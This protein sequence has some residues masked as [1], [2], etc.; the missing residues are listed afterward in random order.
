M[1][2]FQLVLD[3]AAAGEPDTETEGGLRRC[4]YLDPHFAQA[5]Y[6]LGMMLEQRGSKA[7]AGKCSETPKRAAAGI[8]CFPGQGQRPEQERCKADAAK[9]GGESGERSSLPAIGRLR[10]PVIMGIPSAIVSISGCGLVRGSF[11]RFRGFDQGNDGKVL[12]CE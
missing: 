11:V 8:H 3:W 9:D 7:E 10:A 6:L 5:R 12:D 1:R 4:L 2:I